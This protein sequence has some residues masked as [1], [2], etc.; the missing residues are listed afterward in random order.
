MIKRLKGNKKESSG[1]VANLNQTE[2]NLKQGPGA[3][4]NSV[5]YPNTQ[6]TADLQKRVTQ[7]TE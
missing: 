1:N 5:Q 6:I 3:L 4:N 7:L 2:N